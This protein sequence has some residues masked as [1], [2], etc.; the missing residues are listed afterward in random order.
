MLELI[1]GGDSG[2]HSDPITPVV[3]KEL[4]DIANQH[5]TLRY[6]FIDIYQDAC[7]VF[8]QTKAKNPEMPDRFVCGQV[9]KIMELTYGDS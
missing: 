7:I 1:Q 8:L 5:K 4:Y 6:G 2:A 3:G 9:R